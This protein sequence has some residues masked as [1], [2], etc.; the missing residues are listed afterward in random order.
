MSHFTR[1]K[2]IPESVSHA[3]VR[4]ALYTQLSTNKQVKKEALYALP[5]EVEEKA[6]HCSVEFTQLS[7][8][9]KNRVV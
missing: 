6:L 4:V 8:P 7:I 5:L 3:T 1:K 2:N 9:I